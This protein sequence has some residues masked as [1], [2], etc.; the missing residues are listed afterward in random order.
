MAPAPNHGGTRAGPPRRS[1]GPDS[2]NHYRILGSW[3]TAGKN[4]THQLRLEMTDSAGVTLAMTDWYHLTID[5]IAPIVDITL[6][7]GTP[8]NKIAPGDTASGTFSA[9]DT[10]FGSYSLD[11]LPASLNPPAPTHLPV[12]TTDQVPSGSWSLRT[13][14]TWA[15]CGYVVQ[16]WAR[17]RSIVNSFPAI[18]NVAYQDVGFCLGL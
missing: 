1:W 14:A 13:D 8:C 6:T 4:G 7:S 18:N 10:Y 11:T 16:L 17:D 12:S 9:T 2:Q 3:Q 15:Q 5:N